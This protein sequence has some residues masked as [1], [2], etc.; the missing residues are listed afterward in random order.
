MELNGKLCVLYLYL[1]ICPHEP[2]GQIIKH[3]DPC[4]VQC[5]PWL[6]APNDVEQLLL[7]PIDSVPESL[8][9][10]VTYIFTRIRL[11]ITITLRNIV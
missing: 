9:G 5:S 1:F 8:S 3:T 11:L 2:Y 6:L 4:S 7:S 10:A